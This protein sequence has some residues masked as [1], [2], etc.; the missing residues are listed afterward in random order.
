MS[1][2]SDS[3]FAM[4]ENPSESAQEAEE[5]DDSLADHELI[6]D[7]ETEEPGTQV[8]FHKDSYLSNLLI[9][10]NRMLLLM[11]ISNTVFKKNG[12]AWHKLCR[13]S[14]ILI[15]FLD[16]NAMSVIIQCND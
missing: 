14:L 16:L 5:S 4:E 1:I 6:I 3:N 11:L 7:A 15:I 9:K 10:E 8:T 13:C 2:F 12:L